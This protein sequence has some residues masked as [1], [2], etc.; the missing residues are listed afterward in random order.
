MWVHCSV[1]VAALFLALILS[2]ALMLGKRFTLKWEIWSGI[3]EAVPKKSL[4]VHHSSSEEEECESVKLS[5]CFFNKSI[6]GVWYFE[7]CKCIKYH[8]LGN[9]GFVCLFSM[10]KKRSYLL[11]LWASLES[12]LFFDTAL[13]NACI[14]QNCL[15]HILQS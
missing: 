4:Y 1:Y 15:L 14:Y 3:C 9:F 12:W 5:F 2:F 10:G 13:L 7:I 11:V 8:W 6:K